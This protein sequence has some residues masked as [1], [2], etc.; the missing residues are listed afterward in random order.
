MSLLI[1]I[2]TFVTAG[3]LITIKLKNSPA[4]S[5]KLSKG[6]NNILKWSIFVIIMLVPVLF[7]IYADKHPSI[8]LENGVIRMGGS[9]G[10]DFRVSNIESVDTVNVYPKINLRLGGSSFFVSHIGN[11][12]IENEKEIAK[13]CIYHNRPPFIKIRMKDNRLILLNF[14]DPDKTIEFYNRLKNVQ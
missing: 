1:F 13:L 14:Y 2:I 7:G 5:C 4:L 9:F 6:Q 8:T 10:E 3:V 11:F 12:D